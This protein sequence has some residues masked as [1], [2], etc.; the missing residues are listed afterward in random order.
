MLLRRSFVRVVFFNKSEKVQIAMIILTPSFPARLYLWIAI[1]I[2]PSFSSLAQ[3]NVV[4]IM[5]DD[6]GYGDLGFHGN[7]HIQTPVLDQ[8]AR[9]S[10]IFDQFY[11]TPVCATTRASLMT[12]RYSLRTG[13]RDTYNGGAMM[14]GSEVTLAE[15]LK[16]V[17][18]KTGIFGKWHLGDNYPFRPGDQGFDESVI[19]LSGGMGQVGDITTYFKGERS[20]FDPVLWKNGKPMAF[21]GY[22]SDIFADQAIRFIEENHEKS[23]FCFLSFNAPHTPLQVPEKYYN[24]YKDIDPA[25]GFENDNRPF[26]A[27]TEKDKEDAR[28]VYAMVHNIDDNIGK[29]LN[30]LNEFGISENTIVIFMTDNGPQQQRFNSGMRG[31]KSSVFRG[32]VR[33]PFFMKYP[34][35]SKKPMT[36]SETASVTDVF[37]TIA[38]LCGVQIPG[39]RIID[40][41]SLTPLIEGEKDGFESRPHFFYWTRKYPELYNNM[42]LMKGDFRLVGHADYNAPIEE[43]GLYDYS[44]DPYEQSNL[45]EIHRQRALEMKEEMTSMYSELVLSENLLNPPRIVIGSPN[46]NPTILNRNDA[47]GARGIWAQEEIFGKWNVS[48][49]EGRYNFRIKFIKPVPAN[50]KMTIETQTVAHQIMNKKEDTDVIEMNDIQLPAIEG[51][52]IP[53]YQVDGRRI[54]PF[55][56]EV[57]RLDAAN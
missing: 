50:G 4:L 29:L 5:T 57:M 55:W 27:M 26:V 36:I 53:F 16:S 40:G 47:D 24:I 1:L 18:Y 37:P 48:I 43:F 31:L 51:E 15:I 35:L 13:V 56:I 44:Q 19:H 17:N 7:P 52:L 21:H 25:S 12:G 54:F 11:V 42:A 20:Y 3:P 23:F 49:R 38:E 39:D 46:E 33:V 41:V 45:V 22:C 14:A 2:M 10:I 6:Q 34:A 8:L 30:K 28:K 32:G 9:E